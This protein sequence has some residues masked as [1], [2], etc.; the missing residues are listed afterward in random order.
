MIRL[1][2]HFIDNWQARVGN[3][4]TVEQVS[5]ILAQC[6]TV[7]KGRIFTLANGGQYNTLTLYWHPDLNL[8][9]SYDAKTKKMVSVLSRDNLKAETKRHGNKAKSDKNSNYVHMTM[10]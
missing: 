5:G 10:H 1:S 8:I 4:P 9:L 3:Y 7:Q 6:I 2:K